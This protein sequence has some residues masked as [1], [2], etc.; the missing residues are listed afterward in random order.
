MTEHKV[1]QLEERFGAV[2]ARQ[3][4]GVDL[5]ALRAKYETQPVAFLREVLNAEPWSKQR[6]IAELAHD[7]PLVAVASANAVGKG[8]L[9]ARL[10]LWWVFAKGGLVLV[11]SAVERQVVEAF[12]AELGRA[13]RGSK[14]PGELYQHKFEVPGLDHAGVLA[15][16]STSA[17]RMTG[18]HAPRVLAILD[19][20]Q[21]CEDFAWEGLLSCATGDDDRLLVLGNPMDVATP[22][23]RCFQPHSAWATVQL[24]A[25]SHPNL[26]GEEPRIEG[27]PTAVWV[28]RMAATYGRGSPTFASRVLAQFP[29]DAE[30]A[31]VPRKWLEAAVARW[32][33]RPALDPTQPTVV[34]LDIARLGGDSCALAVRQGEALHELVTWR[35]TTTTETVVRVGAELERLGLGPSARDR[36]PA[37]FASRVATVTIVVDEIGVGAGVLD[38]LSAEGRDVVGFNAGRRPS[39]AGEGRFVNARAEAAW[40]L[41]SLLEQGTIALPPDLLLADELTGLRYKT[42]A[43]SGRLSLEPK[44]DLAVRLGRSPDRADAAVMAFAFELLSPYTMGG[45]HI[46]L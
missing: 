22:F 40:T 29:A 15:F 23:G 34:G 5:D 1:A 26:T 33:E 24:D 16:T 18:H 10:A 27:G 28:E 41:R 14:L 39:S 30:Y 2:I 35:G 13:W 11:T 45:A 38:V 36:L 20:A 6:A 17:S 43:V 21:G 42:E 32:Q 9:A 8:W 7:R 44:G 19:E 31:L 25:F 37:R 46:P 3:R 12:M 4:G